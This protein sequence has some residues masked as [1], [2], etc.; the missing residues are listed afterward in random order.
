VLKAA[1][2][3]SSTESRCRPHNLV[4]ENASS[5][6]PSANEG[7][8]SSIATIDGDIAIF[9]PE[10]AEEECQIILKFTDAK[11]VITQN[12]HLRTRAQRHHGRHLQKVSTKKPK[13]GSD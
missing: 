6:R 10:G 2:S 1:K 11:L 8:G 9:K 13:F 7:E 4:H 3:L 12:R 5:S